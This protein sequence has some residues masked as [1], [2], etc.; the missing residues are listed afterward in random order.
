MGLGYGLS[1]RLRWRCDIY[2]Y[3]WYL[4]RYYFEA[5]D[6]PESWSICSDSC[7]ITL[8]RCGCRIIATAS[9]AHRLNLLQKFQINNS[10]KRLGRPNCASS[11]YSGSQS[12]FPHNSA[13]STHN[14]HNN[15]QQ[16]LKWLTPEQE[17]SVIR[18]SNLAKPPLK[19]AANSTGDALAI[20]ASPV[21]QGRT[22]PP[23][24]CFCQDAIATTSDV[25]PRAVLPRARGGALLLGRR[26]WKSR[27]DQKLACFCW[28]L[29]PFRFTLFYNE[30]HNSFST[31]FAWFNTKLNRN[32]NKRVYQTLKKTLNKN[33]EKNMHFGDISWSS[34]VASGGP[35]G[36][37]ARA[38]W[39]SALNCLT[40]IS[41]VMRSPEMSHHFD[42]SS[43]H[44]FSVVFFHLCYLFFGISILYYFVPKCKAKMWNT[45]PSA[46]I[47]KHVLFIFV[48]FC[49]SQIYIQ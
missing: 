24:R 2:K 14:N 9:Q 28:E 38:C 11:F 22:R 48:Y 31:H 27:P 17:K 25:W 6:V 21:S 7:K 35:K 40:C 46:N 10:V 23:G 16:D 13:Y 8:C 43:L 3:L 26:H 20:P 34:K 15:Q 29:W 37:K 19:L 12:G 42:D 18:D 49:L 45:E 5:P 32:T 36:P 44:S 47:C 33:T 4:L 30:L 41:E 1:G 39:R